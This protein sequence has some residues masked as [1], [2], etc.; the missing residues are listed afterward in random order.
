MNQA[1]SA[2]RAR[3]SWKD[4]RLKKRS[5]TTDPVVA[6]A[7]DAARIDV[8]VDKVETATHAALI[9]TEDKLDGNKNRASF[10]RSVCS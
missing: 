7:E 6:A 5:N 8:K 10:T 1:R 9:A 4:G 2:F 3:Q